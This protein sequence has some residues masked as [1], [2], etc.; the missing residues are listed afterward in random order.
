MLAA[1]D[2]DINL[3][4]LP[5]SDL[6]LSLYAWIWFLSSVLP[7]LW[8]ASV[9]VFESTDHGNAPPSKRFV[10]LV[11]AD[12]SSREMTKLSCDL[13]LSSRFRHADMPAS[14][15][16]AQQ[17]QLTQQ[18]ELHRRYYLELASIHHV[19][20]LDAC[21]QVDR[22]M[23]AA[24]PL[25]LDVEPDIYLDT[26]VISTTG[27]TRTDRGQE[28]P[29][30]Q[31]RIVRCTGIRGR[32]AQEVDLEAHNSRSH[33]VLNLFRFVFLILLLTVRNNVSGLGIRGSRPVYQRRYERMVGKARTRLVVAKR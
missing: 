15:V 11:A 2:I 24:A 13:H 6:D 22:G 1:S 21:W 16:L 10:E 18:T 28:D 26:A 31:P 17:P 4:G 14:T 30:R 33:T 5:V 23:L 29:R 19:I 3:A 9:M 12:R 7:W 20:Q 27:A 32:C 25:D 8:I